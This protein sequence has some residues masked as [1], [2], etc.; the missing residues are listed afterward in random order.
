MK[1]AA[2]IPAYRVREKIVGVVSAIG[3]EIELII[4]VDDACP[5]HSGEFVKGAVLDPR[6][7]VVF[8]E[9]NKGVG[10]A[11]IAGMIRAR[12]LGADLMVKIDG[13]GQMNP[14]LAPTFLAPLIEGLA[15]VTKGNRFYFLDHL[16]DMPRLRLYGNAF[17]SFLTKASSGYWNIFDPTN[18]Y[19]AIRGDT[20]DELETEKLARRY[21]FESDLLFRLY[22]SG[23]VV[24]DIPMRAVYAD[25]KSKL[26]IR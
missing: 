22:L 6:L 26:V 7:H 2:I 10:G 9:D 5:E 3:P 4:V 8:N 15:D 12:E 16:K 24:M 25:E 11:T 21:F 14:A 23:A 20:F 17:L 19:I 13:D 1:T 18:G